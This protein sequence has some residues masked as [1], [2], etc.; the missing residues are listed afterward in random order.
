[1]SR[2]MQ[3]AGAVAML[4]F[5]IIQ[6]AAAAVRGQWPNVMLGIVFTAMAAWLGWY[7]FSEDKQGKEGSH[8]G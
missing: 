5:G 8:E 2:V 3:T 1:M 6:A 4:A 7:T